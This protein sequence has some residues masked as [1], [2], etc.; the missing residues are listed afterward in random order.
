MRS[1][2]TNFS[3][4]IRYKNHLEFNKII[5]LKLAKAIYIVNMSHPHTIEQNNSTVSGGGNHHLNK[6]ETQYTLVS[7]VQPILDIC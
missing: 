7:E 6:Q 3:Q 1:E 2:I 4:E 5:K